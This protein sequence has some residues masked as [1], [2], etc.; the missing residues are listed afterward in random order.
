MKLL[1][2]KQNC[3]VL[4]PSFYTDKS[5]RDLYISRI[6]L[7]ILLQENMWTDPGNI[8]RSQTHECGNWEWGN[9][10]ME[11][12]LQSSSLSDHVHPLSDHLLT[13]HVHKLSN[14]IHSLSELSLTLTIHFLPDHVH[15]ITGLKSIPFT[16]SVIVHSFPYS[17]HAF[18][19][20][21]HAYPLWSF[22]LPL[23]SSTPSRAMF[24]FSLTVFT[25][26]MVMFTSSLT[27]FTPSLTMYSNI[28]PN[29]NHAHSLSFRH[30]LFLSNH[31]YFLIN[32]VIFLVSSIQFALNI[33]RPSPLPVSCESCSKPFSKHVH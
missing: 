5:V 10:P 27:M 29:S 31:I 18:S 17:V 33:F 16:F 3:N 30:D 4:S 8:N 14:H 25:P 20:N 21:V 23:W 12:S 19:Y 13:C 22:S 7:P 6:R 28:S 1:F 15:S 32:K 11:F 2:P 24:T 26:F 9:T